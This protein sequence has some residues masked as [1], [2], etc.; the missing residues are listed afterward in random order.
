MNAGR[1]DLLQRL[2]ELERSNRQLS[3]EVQ[4][5]RALI[6]TPLNVMLFSLDLNYNYITFNQAHREF[7]KHNW[8]LD[9]HP[10]MHVF[11]VLNEPDERA[12]SRRNFDRVLAGE[13]YILRRKYRKPKG[14]IGFYQNTYVPLQ[15]GGEILGAV[16]F[17]HDIT[18]WNERE[19]EGKKYRAIF[20]KALEG[21]YRSTSGGRFIEANREMARILGY[22]SPQDLM[23]TITDISR[24]LYCDPDDRE[25]VFSILRRDGVL[26][27]FE[28]RMR[29]KDGSEIWVEFNA[30]IEKDDQ[31]RTVFIEG[32]LTDITTRKE[33]ERKAQLRGQKMI[34]ADKMASLGVLVAGVA[35]EIN[36]P[37]SFL[38]LNL[39]LLRDVWADA[40]HVLDEYQEEHGDFVLGGLEYSELR[41]QMPLLLQGMVDGSERIKDIVSR[42]K[43]YSRQRPE[44]ERET[45]DVNSVVAGAL[46]FVRQKLKTAAPGYLVRLG[47]E[48]VL[49]EADLQRLIQVLI[50]LLV[51]ACEAVPASDGEITLQVLS[52][53]GED[54]AWAGV[55]VRDNGCGIL[56]HDLKYIQD[57]FFTTKR[58]LGGTGLGLSISSAIMHDHG[59]R[60]EFSSQPGQGTCVRMLL[61]M[62]R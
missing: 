57:P 45:T 4:D 1:E 54:K 10:G 22:D 61:P 49:V 13:S 34:Q 15:R 18:E 37:N 6:D 14:E 5:L 3:R 29:R 36:N 2:R 7:V 48:P 44:G 20:E 46:A 24:Q 59:G 55:E 62:T 38:T 53:Y 35:H 17:A 16:V 30:R 21:I 28:T 31:G 58:E 42:L 60:L 56:P 25:L 8:K 27:D 33:A 50:N 41:Q 11:D 23:S 39:P 19:E 26:K 40:L 52:G 32:K 12:S 47:A 51:N 43:D 9:I